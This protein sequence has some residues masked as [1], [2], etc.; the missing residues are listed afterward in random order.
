MRQYERKDIDYETFYNPNMK[1]YAKGYTI[2][3][4]NKML[5]KANV[6]SIKATNSH[7]LAIE[8]SSS[9][10]ANSS[11]RAKTGVSVEIAGQLK[12]DING[13]LEIHELFPEFAK[14]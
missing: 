8:K 12:L 10:Q 14:A 9:M 3:E 1:R 4:L 2:A 11:N 6:D 5:G 7:R 13:A